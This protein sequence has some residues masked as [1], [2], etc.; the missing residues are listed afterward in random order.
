MIINTLYT[1]G[2]KGVPFQLLKVAAQTVNVL[3]VDTRYKA[4]SPAPQWRS[5]YMAKE[6][7]GHY[8][9]LPALGNVNYKNGGDVLIADPDAGVLVVVQALRERSVILLCACENVETCHR[10]VVA[11]LVQAAE[12]CDI[13]HL[14]KV[15][16]ETW[17]T[18][19]QPFD[20]LPN[21]DLTQRALVEGVPEKVV[22]PKQIR[23]F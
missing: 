2:Y 12:T 6:L 4:N 23:L 7:G 9:H 13:K 3:V 20:V 11:K 22:K 17:T 10:L 16:L 21:M 1:L 8:L 14:S 15:D 5:G 19:V 18:P